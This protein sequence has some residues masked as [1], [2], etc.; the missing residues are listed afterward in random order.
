VPPASRWRER[1][2]QAA[3]RLSAARAAIN[4]LAGQHTVLAQNL[5]ASAVI[6]GLAWQ[7]PRP[8]D[9]AAVAARLAELG[10]RPWQIELTAAALAE[11]LAAAPAQ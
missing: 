8:A 5:L 9:R 6:R 10:A 4:S 7:P 3:A 11:A 2:P 1:D